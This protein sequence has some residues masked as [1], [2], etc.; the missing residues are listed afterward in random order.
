MEISGKDL[1][2]YSNANSQPLSVDE[3]VEFMKNI[4]F[5]PINDKKTA[6]SNGE[7]IVAD[8]QKSNVVKD[9][10]G[11]IRVIDADCK[12]HTRDLGGQYDYLPVEHNFPD[13]NV[14]MSLGLINN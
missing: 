4:G 13:T 12:L 8:L 5:N 7:I 2:A 3:R 14:L 10:N 11:N 1:C 6:F 9:A